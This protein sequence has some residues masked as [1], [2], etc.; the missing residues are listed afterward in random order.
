M[1]FNPVL[2]SGM[3]HV[4]QVLFTP[5]IA[6]ALHARVDEVPNTLLDALIDE[7]LALRFLGFD[8]GALAEEGLYGGDAPDG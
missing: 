8:A 6:P 4:C 3:R 7:T 5:F 1:V 2:N